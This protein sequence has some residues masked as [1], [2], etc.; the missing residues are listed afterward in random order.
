M[1][2]RRNKRRNQLR[3]T[4]ARPLCVSWLGA[5]EIKCVADGRAAGVIVWW[6]LD[7]YP[8][9]AVR[10]T[11]AP[12]WA[13]TEGF[14]APEWSWHWRQ[15][16]CLLECGAL[17]VSAGQSL[18]C[19]V[20]HDDFSVWFRFRTG[21]GCGSGP[22]PSS[23]AGQAEAAEA[24]VGTQWGA[25]QPFP[26]NGSGLGGPERIWCGTSCESLWSRF[27]SL[28]NALVPTFINGMKR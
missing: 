14:L 12:R 15:A 28:T 3:M 24:T 27:S 9:S 10:Y 4:T 21:E 11:T 22:G 16:A 25:P 13:R 5:Q 6:D 19:T 23:A 1:L 7:L 17:A 8:E 20:A 18:Q 2:V 26:L